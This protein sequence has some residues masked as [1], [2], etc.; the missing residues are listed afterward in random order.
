[1]R[2][3]TFFV[4]IENGSDSLGLNSFLG[5]SQKLFL[6]L[7]ISI[8][9]AYYRVNYDER[10]WYRLVNYMNSDGFSN[11]HSLNRAQLLEDALYFYKQQKLD[12]NLLVSITSYLIQEV[13]YIPWV[14]GFKILDHLLETTKDIEEFKV[15]CY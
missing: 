13:D 1:M 15:I 8:F 6:N 4:S 7:K 10:N 2:Y 9:S 3:K 12:R 11:I 14:P 5:L